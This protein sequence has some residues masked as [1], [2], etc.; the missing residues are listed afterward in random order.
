MAAGLSATNLRST[1]ACKPLISRNRGSARGRSD[2]NPDICLV[3]PT[4]PDQGVQAQTSGPCQQWFG[5]TAGRIDL[6]DRAMDAR[7][8]EPCDPWRW[9]GGVPSRGWRAW[10]TG[11]CAGSYRSTGTPSV[12]QHRL[13]ARRYGR[14]GEV[15][16]DRGTAREQSWLSGDRASA[17]RPWTCRGSPIWSSSTWECVSAARG[18]WPSS[19]GRGARSRPGC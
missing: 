8:S 7:S 6:Y 16:P 9:P 13:G 11:P 4:G 14:S 10:P 3:S 15:E 12:R 2:S 1:T 19:P 17:A 18:G 5:C